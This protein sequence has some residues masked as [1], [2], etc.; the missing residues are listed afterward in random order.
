MPRKLI[1]ITGPTAVGK[2]AWSIPLAHK[3]DSPIIS[4]DSRQI[5]REMSIGTAVPSAEELAQ[6]KHYFIQDHTIHTPYTAGDYEIEALTL[7]NLLFAEGHEVLVASGGTGFYVD[8][9][10]YGLGDLPKADPQLRRDLTLR[11]ESEGI[12]SL[13]MDLCRL[14]PEAYASIDLTNPQRIIRAVEVCL[15]SGRKFSSFALDEPKKRDFEVEI[16]CLLRSREELAERISLRVD[17]MIEAGLVDEV[18][19]LLPQ[20]G[21]PALRTVGYTEIFDYLDGNCSLPEAVEKIKTSTR[22]YAKR[23]LTWWRHH[24]SVRFVEL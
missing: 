15:L 17:A 11:L 9:L 12:E 19:G 1:V 8:A 21:L 4:C 20:R 3:Y 22:H 13:R 23:Q 16:I 18:R 7:I 24:P 10:L 6:V 2:T 5:Y 14:D